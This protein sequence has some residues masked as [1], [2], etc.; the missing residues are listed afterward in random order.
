MRI[1]VS[2]V[3]DVPMHV[4]KSDRPR[5]TKGGEGEIDQQIDRP[6]DKCRDIERKRGGGRDRDNVHGQWYVS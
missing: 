6:I 3:I 5:Q 1:H 2:I 4:N